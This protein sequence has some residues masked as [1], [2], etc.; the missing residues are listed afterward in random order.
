MYKN[1]VT[2]IIMYK[3]FRCTTIFHIEISIFT[4]VVGVSFIQ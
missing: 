1:L 3:L 2:R 4:E